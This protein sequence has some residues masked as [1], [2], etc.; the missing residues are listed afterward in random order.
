MPVKRDST[1]KFTAV[2]EDHRKKLRAA[3]AI[4]AKKVLTPTDFSQSMRHFVTHDLSVVSVPSVYKRMI[5]A[6]RIEHEMFT[7]MEKLEAALPKR[8]ANHLGLR[9]KKPTPA[10]VVVMLDGSPMDIP[11]NPLVTTDQASLGPVTTRLFGT[12][13][14][15][16]I[17]SPGKEEEPLQLGYGPLPPPQSFL[18]E[19]KKID[20]MTL[21]PTG[22]PAPFA[23]LKVVPEQEITPARLSQWS[24]RKREDYGGS[25]IA[26][27]NQCSAGKY[28][29]WVLS[30]WMV[31]DDEL[32]ELEKSDWEWLHLV[33][34]SMGGISHAPQQADNL[35]A[36]TSHANTEMMLY[37]NAIKR[38][39]E[40][41]KTHLWVGVTAKLGC[42]SHLATKITYTVTRKD[43]KGDRV[44]TFQTNPLM[45]AA[46]S[47]GLEAITYIAMK[48]K[49]FG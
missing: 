4:I 33:A 12:K 9:Q 39:V 27:M 48:S 7:P 46:P 8:K 43:P 30:T 34:F 10:K 41:T 38:L 18:P 45:V 32:K 21:E 25:Q 26:V 28:A 11:A 20:I 2:P 3:A 44:M 35:V 47:H 23:G 6:L 14:S 19:A 17:V 49:L 13:S 5:E 1:P 16:Q 37:E 31:T 24:G 42:Y 40:E 22:I 15:L 36:G 29:R